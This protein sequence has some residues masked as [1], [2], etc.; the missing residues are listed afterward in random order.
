M[1]DDLRGRAKDAGLNLSKMLRDAVVLELNHR[2]ALD[3]AAG[4]AKELLLDLADPAGNAYRGRLIG[5]VLFENAKG[6]QILV[7]HDRRIVYYNPQLLVHELPEHEEAIQ[8]RVAEVC[9]SS[10]E[11][12]EMMAK[13]GLKAIIDL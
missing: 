7:T 13:L 10:D 8:E 6:H 4:D 9:D 11:R 2:R 12:I 1:P 5:K 3:E